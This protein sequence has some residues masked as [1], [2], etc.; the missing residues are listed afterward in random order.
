[1][2]RCIVVFPGA[3]MNQCGASNNNTGVAKRRFDRERT[4]GNNSMPAKLALQ[5]LEEPHK[6]Q[7][8]GHHDVQ[9]KY[10]KGKK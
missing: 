5:H 10:S 3:K 8:S 4:S 6:D 9:Q 2:T 7:Q 1:M